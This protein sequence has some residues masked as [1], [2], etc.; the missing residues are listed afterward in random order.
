[1]KILL[2]NPP[3]S[4]KRGCLKHV[5]SLYPSL[6]LA[7]IAA[8]AEDSGSEVQIIDCVAMGFSSADLYVLT[9]RFNPE[10]IGMQTLSYNINDCLLAAKGI[11]G[12]SPQ[13]NI[14]FGGVQASLFPTEICNDDNVDFVIAGEGELTFKGLLEAM[15]NGRTFDHV[16]GLTW[17]EGKK[18]I[19]NPP[20][21]LIDDL[22]TLPLPAWHLFCLNR[23]H[24]S[25]QL[26]GRTTLHLIT[27]RGCPYKCAYCAA[28]KVFGRTSRQYT[29]GRIIEEIIHLRK[30]YGADVIQFYDDNFTLNRNKVIDLCDH[31]IKMKLGIPWSCFSRVDRIDKGLLRKM[32]KAGCY[33]IFYGVES[34]SQRLLDLIR[35]DIT[36]E[37]IK[38]AF[39]ITKEEGIEAMASLIMGLPTE[40]E[41]DSRRTADIPI[42]IDADYAVWSP[43]GVFPGSDLFEIAMKHGR[44][45]DFNGRRS[46]AGREELIKNNGSVYLTGNMSLNNLN[47]KINMAYKK[48]YL[49]PIYIYRRI[50]SFMK[51]PSRKIFNIFRG[52]FDLVFKESRLNFLFRPMGRRVNS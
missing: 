21:E 36:L 33:Q 31:L 27:S 38:E 30:R 10:L 43:L 45:A 20:R 37:Q 13:V 15:G 25:A 6:G 52:G 8:V 16:N 1:M 44:L 7:Y 50:R 22:D 42:K 4:V 23:Y 34:G 18:I 12:F 17:K 49:R 35:K 32:K 14:V 51:L 29:N 39:K 41:E 3:V 28:P 2:I 48:F 24:S 11:K 46:D 26:R 19:Q 47:K 40:T 5:E 9:K